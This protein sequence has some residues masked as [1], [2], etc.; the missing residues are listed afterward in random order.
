V[1]DGKNKAPFYEGRRFKGAVAVIGLVSALIAVTGI[2]K[3]SEVVSDLSSASVA[4]S[5][6]EIVLDTS[7]DM[8]GRFEGQLTRLD[9]AVSAI[10]QAGERDDEGLA[11]R[12][13][14][15][16]CG[17]EEDLLVGFGTNHKGDVLDAAEEQRPAGASNIVNAVVEALGDFR[18]EAEFSGPSSTR[19]VLVFTTGRDECFEGDVASKIGGELEAAQVSASFTLI[20]LNVSGE[21]LRQLEELRNA[22]KAADAHV[23]TRTPE[24]SEE[25]EGVV[26]EVK[27]ASRKAVKEGKNDDGSGATLGE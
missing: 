23:E 26:E 27:D 21:A 14:S 3:L 7:A 19:R 6:T 20:A 11:L 16:T 18:N 5:N 13:T 22:L 24:S 8:G 4:V 10:E 1:A 25:L 12:R 17:G 2:P 9:A 15:P